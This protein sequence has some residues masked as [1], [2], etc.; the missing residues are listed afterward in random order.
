MSRTTMKL[1]GAAL[2]AAALLLSSPASA[3]GLAAKTSDIPAAER[4]K[5]LAEIA[6]FKQSNPAAFTEVHNV[7]GHL[8]EGYRNQRNP[9]PRVGRELR[10]L[11]KSALLPMLE[12]LAIKEPPRRGARAHEWVALQVGMLEAVGH[13]R[14]VRSAAVLHAIFKGKQAHDVQRSAAEAMGQLCDASSLELLRVSLS[15]GDKRTAAVH[16]LGQCRRLEAA[17][18]LTTELAAVT[19]SGE[20]IVIARSLGRLGSSWA[21]RAKG[22]SWAAEGAKVRKLLATALVRS[23][24]RFGDR[25]SRD[26]HRIGLTMVKH[27]DTRAIVA[28]EASTADAATR[29][30][31]DVIAKRIEKRAR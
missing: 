29:K 9:V 28:S 15:A 14:D 23:Y 16:G 20:A 10:R 12:A 3:D 21:W 19:S 31:L 2:T 13:L 5:L 22:P 17:K 25:D 18:L 24:L 8:P 7:K 4:A 6:T 27:V 26:A 30:S 11:G 1:M